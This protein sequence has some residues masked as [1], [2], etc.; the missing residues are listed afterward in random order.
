MTAELQTK[1]QQLDHFIG[2]EYVPSSG[3]KRFES[4]NPATGQVIARVALGTADDIDR[5]VKA[6]HEAFENGPWPRMSLKERCD[7]LH[8]IAN[9]ILERRAVLAKAETLD[10]GKPISE[11]IDGDI[12]RAALNFQFFA[13][14]VQSIGEEYY[15]SAE[16]ERHIAIR[17]PLGVCGLITPWNLPLYLATWKIA[18]CLAMGNTCVLKPAEWTPYTAY[19]FADI[20]REAGLPPGVFNIVQGFGADGAG[21]ALTR[22]PLV[23]SISFTGETG[24][25]KAIMAAASATLKRVSFELGGK[26]ANI[27]FTDAD[28]NEAIPTAIRAAFRNQGEIC[29]AGSRL[30]V[31]E[32]IVDQVVEQIVDRARQIKVGD[33]LDTQTQM[34]ALISKEHL[35]KVES[36]IAMGKKDGKLLCGGERLKEIPEGNFLT[37]AVFTGLPYDSRFCQEEIF[38]PALP[39]VPFKTDEDAV[40][41]ANST[42][43]G[44]S[45]S[46]WSQDVDRCHRISRQLRSGLVWVNCWF[47]RD[48]RTP[49]GGQKQSGVGREG[50]LHSLDFFSETKTVSYRYK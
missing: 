46:I 24:T 4:I 18:P 48:L 8:K 15:T 3:G 36:Y 13:N 29:L 14:F 16:N 47:A 40:R 17:E 31:H 22:H 30:F 39:I 23:R 7:I 12:P 45:A 25:G 50:G 42:P 10:T 27:L 33:P 34:G 37:P 32:K 35:E 41:M 49:F 20:V 19:L 38:G 2:G 11:S 5:A 9:L 44:L 6:A 21:E 28:L 43:Y 1:I 26:G